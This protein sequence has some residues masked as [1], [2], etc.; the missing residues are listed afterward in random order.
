M[1]AKR[2]G[3]YL[4]QNMRRICFHIQLNCWLEL[5]VIF[6]L[7]VLATLCHTKH[8]SELWA[9]QMKYAEHK[10]LLKSNGNTKGWLG[11]ALHNLYQIFPN[12]PKQTCRGYKNTV[13]PLPMQI[14]D[15]SPGSPTF[16]S[17]CHHY[18]SCITKY[19]CGLC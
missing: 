1:S 11:V 13:L 5:S 19:C 18:S 9:R 4:T 15:K 8:A 2:V 3:L 6:P 16:Q 10:P 12:H 7:P 14:Q 17:N